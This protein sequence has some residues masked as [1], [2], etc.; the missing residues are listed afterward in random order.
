MIAAALY[1]LAIVCVA[2]EHAILCAVAVSM[3]IEPASIWFG[4]LA[5]ILSLS[6]CCRPMSASQL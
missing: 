6:I 5:T 4:A 1:E 2:K 3:N